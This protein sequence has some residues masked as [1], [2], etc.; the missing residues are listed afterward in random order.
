M[1]LWLP[2]LL[3]QFDLPASL[4]PDAYIL[5]IPHYVENFKRILTSMDAQ[6]DPS[7]R[8]QLAKV[9]AVSAQNAGAAILLSAALVTAEGVLCR[10][11]KKSE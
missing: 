5:D 6:G 3:G 10:C 8:N 1:L 11:K 9:A 2:Q 4:M 7:V